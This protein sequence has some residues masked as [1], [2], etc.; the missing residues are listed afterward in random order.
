MTVAL[1]TWPGLERRL[2]GERVV[3][4]PLAPEHEA[5]LFEAGSDE[6]VW[7]WLDEYAAVSRER[8]HEWMTEA[9]E[10]SAAGVVR[11]VGQRESAYYSVID[12]EWPPVRAN[13]ERRLSH[14]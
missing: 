4:E 7:R 14:A 9:L 13:P 5:D 3:M 8:F 2:E 1:G 6:R 10:L 12:D 11:G